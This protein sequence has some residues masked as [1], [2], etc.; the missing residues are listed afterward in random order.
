MGAVDLNSPHSFGE[1]LFLLGSPQPCFLAAGGEWVGE[2]GSA[3]AMAS[4]EE[5]SAGWEL[6][7]VLWM[8]DSRG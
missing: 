2:P 4:S 7:T 3:L 6:P 8:G 5:T 1:P